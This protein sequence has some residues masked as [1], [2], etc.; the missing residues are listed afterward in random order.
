ML[1]TPLFIGREGPNPTEWKL[2]I[3][4]S[5]ISTAGKVILEGMSGHCAECVG[6]AWKWFEL[7]PS[8]WIGLAGIAAKPHERAKA[9]I[10]IISELTEGATLGDAA[11]VLSEFLEV[12]LLNL[13]ACINALSEDDYSDAIRL[14]SNSVKTL[15]NFSDFLKIFLADAE[16]SGPQKIDPRS[17]GKKGGEARSKK[18]AGLAEYAQARMSSGTFKSVR[19]A[20]QKIT[21]GVIIEAAK[22]G[23]RL[24]DDNAERTVYDWLRKK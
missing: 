7:N 4:D 13:Y 8:D 15:T 20:A 11:G 2:V 23:V 24:S 22:I 21:P 1:T 16:D 10:P 5:G 18:Y 17:I 12:S 3:D 9:G 19:S 6:T 14:Y